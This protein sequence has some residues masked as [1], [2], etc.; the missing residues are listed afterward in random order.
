MADELKALEAVA[1]LVDG[2]EPGKND[3]VA[4]FELVAA[5]EIELGDATKKFTENPEFGPEFE[6][7]FTDIRSLTKK[8]SDSIGALD[9]EDMLEIKRL[10]EKGNLEPD[11]RKIP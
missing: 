7:V 8:M 2:D 6:A 1:K 10:T 4:V 11:K 9:E 3:I 5:L